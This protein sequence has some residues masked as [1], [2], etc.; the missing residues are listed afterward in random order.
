MLGK[1]QASH[2]TQDSHSF[3][4]CVRLRER[5]TW[6]F[7]LWK[8]SWLPRNCGV[9]MGWRKGNWRFLHR[10]GTRKNYLFSSNANNK[11]SWLPKPCS[12]LNC[13]LNEQ[14]SLSI[15]SGHTAANGCYLGGR[16]G[17]VYGSKWMTSQLFFISMAL[18]FFRSADG[19]QR[20]RGKLCQD[21][22]YQWSEGLIVL[23][24]FLKTESKING[25]LW[26]FLQE[27]VMQ[28]NCSC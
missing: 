5:L 19:G 12:P 15:Q 21:V 9:G 20:R 14:L 25:N 4:V 24:A 26:G 10:T 17:T 18:C 16:E 8:T 3:L 6:R 27:T 1:I 22:D 11:I 2:P 13:P 23:N 28:A 7:E